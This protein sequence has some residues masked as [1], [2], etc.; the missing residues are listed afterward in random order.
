MLK[1]GGLF[2]ATLFDGDAVQHALTT[3]GGSV[4]RR[5]DD[6]RLVWRIEEVKGSA[7]GRFGNT[8]KVFVDSINTYQEE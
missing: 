7:K 5:T 8:I 2:A 4:E 3:A 6:D 1:P